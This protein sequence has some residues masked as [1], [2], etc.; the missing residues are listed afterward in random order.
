MRRQKQRY[1]SVN[2]IAASVLVAL[3]FGGLSSPAAF[4]QAVS[5]AQI[6]GT[7]KDQSGAVLPGA[8]VKVTQRDTGAVRSVPSSETGAF[9]LPNLPVGPY[10]LEVSLPGFRTYVQT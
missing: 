6:N 4:A 7:V 9:V 3:V 10:T 8:E 1:S 2:L 5:T